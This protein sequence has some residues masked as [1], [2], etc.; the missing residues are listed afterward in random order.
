MSI[1]VDLHKGEQ[2][3]SLI[4]KSGSNHDSCVMLYEQRSLETLRVKYHYILCR[5]LLNKV[6]FLPFPKSFR[7]TNAPC[8]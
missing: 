2:I 6:R 3:I 1:A 8:A 4:G 7:L 5:V